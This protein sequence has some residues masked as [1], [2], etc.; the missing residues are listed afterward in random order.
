M[1]TVVATGRSMAEARARAYRN[2]ERISFAGV[3]YRRD[4]SLRELAGE[5]R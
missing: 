5:V 4:V 1:L 3:H 2:V